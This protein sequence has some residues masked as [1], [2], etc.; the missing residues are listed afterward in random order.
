MSDENFEKIK[1]DLINDF[2]DITS[3]SETPEG[4]KIV[5]DDDTLWKVFE[6]LFNGVENIE[7]NMGTDEESYIVMKI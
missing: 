5:A 2:P 6:V 4:I 7:F 1:M 3:I